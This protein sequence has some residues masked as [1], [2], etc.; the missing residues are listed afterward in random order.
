MKTGSAS[1]PN[2]C[3]EL[4]GAWPILGVWYVVPTT[5]TWDALQSTTCECHG[6]SYLAAKTPLDCCLAPFSHSDV[7]SFFK[8]LVVRIST[9]K[10]PPQIAMSRQWMQTSR[11]SIMQP[12]SAAACPYIYL[13]FASA[14]WPSLASGYRVLAVLAYPCCQYAS[15]SPHAL[16]TQAERR[17][18]NRNTRDAQKNPLPGRPRT[19]VYRR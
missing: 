12:T 8:D 10:V 3:S 16:P 5:V 18:L 2:N 1:V 19:P 6:W 4:D 9:N 7:K 11:R 14:T 15:P 17:P 13:P